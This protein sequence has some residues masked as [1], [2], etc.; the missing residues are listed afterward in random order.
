MHAHFED[1]SL[2]EVL[3]TRCSIITAHQVLKLKGMASTGNRV[4][5]AVI[6][7]QGQTTQ[8][9]MASKKINAMPVAKPKRFT[10]SNF[11]IISPNRDHKLLSYQQAYLAQYNTAAAYN[12]P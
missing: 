7:I 10:G 8:M 11:I 12:K 1:P 4:L 5:M 6:N 3:I 9:Q 2:I